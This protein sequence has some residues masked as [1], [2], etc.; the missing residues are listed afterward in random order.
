VPERLGAYLH[1][2]NEIEFYIRTLHSSEKLN[3]K[4]SHEYL[5]EREKEQTNQPKL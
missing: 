4:E 3:P 5:R 2:G 1:V